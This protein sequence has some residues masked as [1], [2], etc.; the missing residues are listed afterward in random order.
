ME[1]NIE[2]GKDSLTDLLFLIYQCK[3]KGCL[4]IIVWRIRTTEKKIIKKVEISL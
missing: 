3:N 4:H 1:V 2:V